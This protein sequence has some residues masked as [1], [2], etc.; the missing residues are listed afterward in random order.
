MRTYDI[1]KEYAALNELIENNYDQETGEVFDNSKEIE[2]LLTE[3]NGTRDEKLDNIESLR[4]ERIKEAAFL[5][6]EIDRL[7]ARLSKVEKEDEQLVSLENLL[8][9]GEK[10][11]TALFTFSYRK[12][13][14]VE[15]D[16]M[17]LPGK[18]YAE[19][20]V[21]NPDK[22]AIKAA[23]EEGVEIPGAEIVERSNFGGGK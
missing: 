21:R 2:Q 14:A 19:K 9:G 4:R 6:S 1:V 13:K 11:K 20:I 23:L 18:W 8:C 22:K 10:V 12:S 17:K 5:K 3:L 16:E 7:K 15:I